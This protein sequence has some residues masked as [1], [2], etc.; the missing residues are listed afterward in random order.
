MV[1]AIML[2]NYQAKVRDDQ[3][4]VSFAGTYAE[5]K[6]QKDIPPAFRAWAKS[7]YSDRIFKENHPLGPE[8]GAIYELDLIANFAAN[9]GA[10]V[11]SSLDR[12][13]EPVASPPAPA[14]APAPLTVAL[15]VGGFLTGLVVGLALSGWRSDNSSDG[16]K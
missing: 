8:S 10:D 15:V 6:A 11:A 4:C 7:D 5:C 2:D 3:W 14:P 16:H 9:V 1:F 12:R 13:L